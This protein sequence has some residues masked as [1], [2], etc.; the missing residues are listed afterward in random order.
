VDDEDGKYLAEM[1]RVLSETEAWAARTNAEAPRLRPAPCSSLR[2]DD[3]RTNPYELS[4]A[5][6]RHLS[7]AVDLRE[8]E[9]QTGFPRKFLA[10]RARE[11]GI[12]LARAA[13]P[14]PID[15]D[16]L[17]EQY[18]TRQRSYPDIAAEL[19]VADMTVLAAARRNGIPS[20]PPGMHSRPEM[21]TKLS[22][23]IPRD[24]RRAVEGSLKG[25]HRLRR[26][27]IAM[28]FPTI[29]AAATHL[30]AHQSAL[31]HQF[32]R[33]EHDIGAVLYQPSARGQPMRP[34][35]RGTRAAQRAGP[36]ADPGPRRRPRPRRVRVRPATAAIVSAC[37][38]D[39]GLQCRRCAT[40]Q[41]PVPACHQDPRPPRRGCGQLA[42]AGPVLS[43]GLLRPA[44]T[45]AAARMP[46]RTAPSMWPSH[47]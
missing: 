42:S 8:L 46:D 15:P 36:P 23:D 13:K 37:P 40:G 32:R 19:D 11:H 44:A 21:I 28:T 33:L 31:I 14:A 20:R 35:R 30:S 27:Q 4:H 22:A 43:R 18:L 25:W 24:I 7:N 6:W 38:P 10:E 26:F 45:S 1:L 12:T 41:Q 47:S 9:A 34:T 5:V 2:G 17:R 16:W 39:Q 3:D 29:E